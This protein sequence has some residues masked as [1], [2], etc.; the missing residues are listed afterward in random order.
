[1]TSQDATQ[2]LGDLL[3]G[4][5]EALH[6]RDLD[7]ALAVFADDEQITVIPSEGIEAYRGAAGVRGLMSYICGG[8]RRYGWN[9]QD[10]SYVI[11]G[12]AACVIASGDETIEEDG[13]TT[14]VPY[15]LTAMARR[16]ANGW[17][18]VVLHGSEDTAAARHAERSDS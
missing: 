12:D 6:A 1:M 14:L 18:F 4:L 15:C 17:R 2:E 10:R 8:S 3:D 9:W 13:A 5:G 7:G 16:T 11:D